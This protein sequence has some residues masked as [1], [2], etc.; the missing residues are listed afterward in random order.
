MLRPT[1]ARMIPA[2]RAAYNAAFTEAQYEAFLADLNA[3]FASNPAAMDR[4]IAFRIAE[5]PIFVPAALTQRLKQAVADILTVVTGPDLAP[6]SEG[7]VPSTLLVPNEDAHTQFLAIDFAV[8]AD[9]NGELTPQ[10]IELQGFPSLFAYEVQLGD[11]FRRHF[12]IPEH[13]SHFFNGLDRESYL[14][15]FRRTVL[16]DEAP[17]NVVLLEVEPWLQG[18]AVDFTATEAFLGVRAVDVTAVE[19]DGNQLFYQ[20]DGVRTRITRI[21]NRVIFDE[22][23]QRPDVLDKMQFSFQDDLDVKWAGHPN[24]FFR[25]SKYLMPRLKSPF[26]PASWFVNELTEIPTD[27]ENYVLKPLFSFAGAGVKF[28]VTRADIDAI[29]A[30]DRANF[31]LQRKVRY[32]PALVTPDGDR[33]KAEIRMLLLWPEGDAQPTLA[34]NLVRLSKGEMIGVKFNKDKTWVGGTIAYFE[35]A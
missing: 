27:L 9:E 13:L 1:F 24:W 8:S 21:Y 6:Y 29:P 17:E 33:V 30:P 11:T 10:L 20:R 16:A 14:A 22:L 19:K 23:L 2:V 7:A 15:L 26:V 3:F 5:T 18:T 32:E 25:I 35:E 31:I 34:V 28:H 4:K 12:P